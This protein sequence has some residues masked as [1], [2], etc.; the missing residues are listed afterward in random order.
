MAIIELILQKVWKVPE[1]IQVKKMSLQDEL[2]GC[3]VPTIASN[4]VHTFQRAALRRLRPGMWHYVG[5]LFRLL[6]NICNFLLGATIFQVW[7]KYTTKKIP[8]YALMV[9]FTVVMGSF[10]GVLVGLSLGVHIIIL[11][12]LSI[13]MSAFL[14]M[15]ILDGIA[16]RYKQF[17]RAASGWVIGCVNIRGYGASYDVPYVPSHLRKR[18]SKA[19]AIHGARLY[20][21]YLEDD[22]FLFVVRGHFF[23]KEKVYIGAWETGNQYLDS[24]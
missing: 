7:K 21:E 18:I 6:F 4:L 20:V 13:S 1:T 14:L 16:N 8:S 12:L 11:A 5:P 2:Q 3:G 23:F 17:A 9:P 15:N 22:P 24:V 19:S 10:V